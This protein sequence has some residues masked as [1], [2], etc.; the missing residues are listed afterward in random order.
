[1]DLAIKS[2]SAN[3]SSAAAAQT[4]IHGPN[5]T[6]NY[7]FP[8]TPKRSSCICLKKVIRFLRGEKNL[9][10][11]EIKKLAKKQGLIENSAQKIAKVLEAIKSIDYS[12]LKSDLHKIIENMSDKERKFLLKK[13]LR[14]DFKK[15]QKFLGNQ[16]MN[17]MTLKQLRSLAHFVSE[18]FKDVQTTAGKFNKV[19][20]AIKKYNVEDPRVR[21]LKDSKQFI[22][23]RIF[24]N[25]F[26]TIAVAFNLL[27]LNKEPNTYFETKYML[28]IYWRL[29]EIPIRLF[30]FIFQVIINPIISIPV[31]IVGTLVSAAA[32]HVFKKIFHRCPDQLP[33][34][35]NLTD[36][37]KN[38]TIKP[39]FG[40][41]KEIDEI[42]ESLAA[43]ND[44]GRKHP[45]LIG[46]TGI[47]KTEL[48]KG[49]ALRL[50]K[51]EVPKALK[52]KKLFYVNSAELMK[53]ANAFAL[54]DPLEQ[55]MHKLDNQ[56]KKVILVFDEAH[57]LV[58]TL[59]ERFNTILDTSSNSLFYAIG[60]T[61]PEKYKEKIE[62]A[63]LDRRFKKMPVE[64]ASEKQTRTILRSMNRQQAPEVE[65]SNETLSAIYNQTKEKITKRHQPDK[66]IFVMSQALERVRHLQNGGEFDEEVRDL[67]AQKEDLASQ[68]SNEK[69][70][71]ISIQSKEVQEIISRLDSVEKEIEYKKQKINEAQKNSAIYIH[72]KK[73]REWHEQWLYTISE[74]IAEDAKKGRKSPDILEKIYLFN[75]FA[76]IPQL[77]RYLS[78]FIEDH[79][80][81][82]HVDEEMITQI[83]EDIKRQENIEVENV[84]KPNEKIVKLLMDLSDVV[85]EHKIKTDNDKANN[86]QIVEKQENIEVIPNVSQKLDLAE[87]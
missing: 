10:A 84:A 49:L 32:L 17:L 79:K 36:E 83:V 75:N 6:K 28:D 48:M 47:G 13:A 2:F 33:Y 42:L 82:T 57:N 50:A 63:L 37:I 54:K 81:K 31:M 72:L 68:L 66:S 26:R 59:G 61:T 73:W 80:I 51:G 5:K 70:H 60:I 30:K 41:E 24:T 16:C 34:C 44:I 27:D 15:G 53:N 9:L 43:N 69:L 64:E 20:Q 21:P 65:I 85:E 23:F 40:R 56:Q 38:G 86:A 22:L 19:I 39:V 77:D 78:D 74:K 87:A 29:L 67:L 7:P 62:P 58:D 18:E 11:A 52:G 46:K 8:P 14:E 35:R 1:M 71:G 4:K 76:L 55:I 45:L 25:F 3:F 12:S